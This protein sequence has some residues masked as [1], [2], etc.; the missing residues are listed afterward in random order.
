MALCFESMRPPTLSLLFGAFIHQS[1]LQLIF[2]S[3]ALRTFT[4]FYNIKFMTTSIHSR[5][6]RMKAVFLLN[7]AEWSRDTRCRDLPTIILTNF[8]WLSGGCLTFEYAWITGAGTKAK[9]RPRTL[10]GQMPHG[11][12]LP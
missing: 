6:H 2:H 5:A 1:G 8:L 11:R 4:Q 12:S 7:G 3:S 9:S 10:D